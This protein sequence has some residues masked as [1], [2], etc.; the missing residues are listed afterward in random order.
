MKITI[1]ILCGILVGVLLAGQINRVVSPLFAETNSP[2]ITEYD[3]TGQ[4]MYWEEIIKST[5]GMFSVRRSWVPGGWL[6]NAISL[7]TGI[8]FYPDPEHKWQP[9]V[10]EGAP[11][12][13]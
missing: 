6:I 12:G 8:T 11:W 4:E 13:K 7:G 1:A 10:K 5:K 3:P 2:V 9:A